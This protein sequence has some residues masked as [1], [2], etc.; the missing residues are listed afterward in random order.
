MARRLSV[1]LLDRTEALA[2]RAVDVAELLEKQRRFARV[3]D[4]L[5]GSG[6]SVGANATEA[7]EAMSAKDFCK[8]LGTVVKE[9]SETAYWLRFAAKRGWIRASRLDSL[10]TECSALKRV[11]GTMLSRT[12]RK[13][14]QPFK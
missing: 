6:P 12:R 1:E 7:D 3:I 11:F 4:Q 10:L 2:H 9:L 8:S 13:V 14:R 5:V